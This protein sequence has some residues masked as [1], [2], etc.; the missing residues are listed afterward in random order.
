M[1]YTV[2]GS[3]LLLRHL[4]LPRH[5]LHHLWHEQLLRYHRRRRHSSL[6]LFGKGPRNPNLAGRLFSNPHQMDLTRPPL[7]RCNSR[8]SGCCF[9]FA[10]LLPLDISFETN[11][12]LSTL[13]HERSSIRRVM[14]AYLLCGNVILKFFDA[15]AIEDEKTAKTTRGETNI[16]EN[17]ALMD[18]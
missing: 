13:R 3:R 8:S 1:S 5:I 2:G 17:D 10:V 11:T 7:L 4:R 6:C 14:S 12:V 9:F 18:G 16:F 15:V